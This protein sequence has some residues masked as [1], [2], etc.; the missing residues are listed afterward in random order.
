MSDNRAKR[1]AELK[2][3]SIV[4]FAAALDID[5]D[6][7]QELRDAYDNEGYTDQF[8][9]EE[10]A[11]KAWAAENPDDAEELEELE[12]ISEGFDDEED[13]QLQVEEFPLD[14]SVRSGWSGLGSKLEAEE[15]AILLC[16]G[17]PAVRLTGDFDRWG[18]PRTATLEYQ[19]WYTPWTTLYIDNPE[20]KQAALRI[21]QYLIPE[22]YVG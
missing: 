20:E 9:T 5:W 17:G 7:L 21:A 14:I 8:E 2:L 16:T 10:D 13:V 19:D 22:V 6:R 15:Y 1:Q 3:G 11:K 12:E 4:Q 18:T